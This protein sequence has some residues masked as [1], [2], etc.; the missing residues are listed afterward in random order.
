[1]SADVISIIPALRARQMAQREKVI[2]KW[3]GYIDD[4]V[5]PV[6][7]PLEPP[8]SFV[9]RVEDRKRAIDITYA[10]KELS[11]MQDQRQELEMFINRLPYKM[12]MGPAAR[13]L[14]E[15]IQKM[16]DIEQY[17]QQKEDEGR[18]K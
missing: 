12:P 18:N 16:R 7:P 9:M 10:Q 1:M 5:L 14:V 13:K 4:A 6:L 3:S 8:V 15:L 2:E 17:I 11:I